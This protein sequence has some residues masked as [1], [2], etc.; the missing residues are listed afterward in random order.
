[1]KNRHDL[2]RIIM[3]LLLITSFATVNAQSATTN[4]S[5][6][7]EYRWKKSNVHDISV[8]DEQAYKNLPVVDYTPPHNINEWSTAKELSAFAEAQ[9]GKKIFIKTILKV[10]ETG[11]V[12]NVRILSAS[13]KTV[14]DNLI[15]IL[16]N[17]KLGAPSYLVNQAVS[18]NIPCFFTISD[19]KIE[20]L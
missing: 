17:T 9:A 1:M 11:V 8:A 18:A 7:K 14:A 3:L 10:D 4:D 13:N 16:V 12:K 20:A 2:K 19:K 5:S 6:A 15:K